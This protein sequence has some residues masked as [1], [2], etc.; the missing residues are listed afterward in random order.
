MAEKK[1][2]GGFSAALR[3]YWKNLFLE[4][5]FVTKIACHFFCQQKP[6]SVLENLEQKA[7]QGG[8]WNPNSQLGEKPT[9]SD[10][11]LVVAF[12][13]AMLERWQQSYSP[14]QTTWDI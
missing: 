14:L 10:D 9:D 7:E 11:F 1:F 4:I 12:H 6:E 8:I 2:S 5:N 3:S 13:A